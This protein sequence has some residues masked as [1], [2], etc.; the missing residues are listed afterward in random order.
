MPVVLAGAH[1]PS[2]RLGRH[3]ARY[4][5]MTAYR[6]DVRYSSGRLTITGWTSL[7]H[8]PWDCDCRLHVARQGSAVVAAYPAEAALADDMV[9]GLAAALDWSTTF[10]GSVHAAWPPLTGAVA[11]VTG[12]PSRMSGWLRT[13][14]TGD[15]YWTHPPP[16]YTYYLPGY[17][18]P[19]RGI[20]PVDDFGGARIVL[21]P[22]ALH[23]T[24]EQLVHELVHYRLSTEATASGFLTA[25]AWVEEGVAQMVQQ[26]YVG[27]PAEAVAEGD[28]V[29][30]STGSGAGVTADRLAAD[31]HDRP[32]TTAQLY[33]ADRESRFFWYQIAA[34]V[35]N[36]LA[37][38]YG[39]K[40]SIDVATVAHRGRSPFGMVPDPDRPDHTLPASTVQ[41]AWAAWVRAT[42]G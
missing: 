31:F 14:T 33:T 18:G 32:P 41:P 7:Q 13:N 5:P 1:A 8:A 12:E 26:I 40:T 35:Y 11:F 42:Y 23:A 21:G 37:V 10:A 29:V 16:A 20:Q 27:T 2:D 34:S 6:W 30:G 9:G 39:L 25:S 4:V 22:D 3:G 36:Y 17:G 19:A 15:D 24:T 28:W 38:T